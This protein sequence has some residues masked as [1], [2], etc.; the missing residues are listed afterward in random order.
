MNCRLVQRYRDAYIDG[1]VDP[2]AAIEFEQHLAGCAA[3]QEAVAFARGLKAQVRDVV[4]E[5]RAPAALRAR[6]VAALDD[7]D[8]ERAEQAHPFVRIVTLRARY[9]VPLAAAAA[10]LMAV[11]FAY[12]ASDDARQA[13]AHNEPPVRSLSATTASSAATIPI[14]EDV[15]RVH[16]SDLPAD[17]PGE[18]PQ[19]VTRWFRN[20]VSFPVR[21]A[22]FERNDAR[23]LG[24]RLS[25]VRERRAAALYY[26]VG[27]SR[28][29]VVVF[30]QPSQQ[31]EQGL[32]RTRLLGREVR[33]QQVGG[34]VVPVR[35]Q[36]GITYAFTGDLDRRSLLRLAATAHVRY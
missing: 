14:F 29:T 12:T 22:E 1:E 18:Q 30:D 21:P 3:C 8:R 23:L 4:A 13:K 25:N 28:V 7:V 17:V 35:E 10:V 36:S 33:Y 27:G 31:L 15:V 34:Y 5:T 9:A 19:E 32:Q 26:D 24:A 16:A 2:T 6:I 20:K 11:S